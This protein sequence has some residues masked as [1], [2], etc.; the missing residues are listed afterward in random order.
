VYV[1]ASFK[2]TFGLRDCSMQREVRL[3]RLRITKRCGRLYVLGVWALEWLA[4]GELKR[5]PPE[6][7]QKTPNA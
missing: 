1:A 2:A 6:S 5:R 7:G 3:G 4:T